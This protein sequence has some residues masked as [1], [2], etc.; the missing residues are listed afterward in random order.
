MNQVRRNYMYEAIT[1]VSEARPVRLY[2]IIVE[3]IKNMI[4]E[5]KLK[6]GDKLPSERELAEMFQ[7]SRVPVREAL[8]V[9]EFMEILQ[10]IP[11]E[12]IYLKSISVNDLLTKIDFMI[13]TSSD[14]IA[15]LFEA[16]EAL[17]IKAVELAV[18]RRTDADLQLM[19]NILADMEEEI[20]KGNDGTMEAANFHTAIY[21]ASKNK[22]IARIR[23]L[24]LNIAEISREKSFR[25]CGSAPVALAFH[26]EI[27][28][29]IRNQNLEGAR[30]TMKDHLET[31][32]QIAL[33]D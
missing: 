14:I 10:Y 1:R 23:D 27:L 3:R 2:E 9:L 26:K 19:E 22:V 18:I 17:E 6:T 21:M 5:G 15:D 20:N 7:V 28:E 11:G 8:K 12:G 16:R 25:K 29:M 33:S 24:L 30:N 31:S 4:L 32:K 13:E